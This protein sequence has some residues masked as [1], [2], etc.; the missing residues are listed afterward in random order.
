MSEELIEKYHYHYPKIGSVIRRKKGLPQ[1]LVAM[2]LDYVLGMSSLKNYELGKRDCPASVLREL[3]IFY[4]C[5]MESLFDEPYIS[6]NRDK[7]K[8]SKIPTKFIK[9]ALDAKP[10]SHQT[11]QIEYY[12]D[13]D[14]DFTN[15]KY[16]YIV[17]LED[18]SSLK[19]PKGTRLL[20]KLKE[21]KSID[22]YENEDIFLVNLPMTSKEKMESP[23]KK[24][25]PILTKASLVPGSSKPKIVTWSNGAET[26]YVN[27]RDF[28]SNID[29][30]VVKIIIDSTSKNV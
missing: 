7:E 8:L 30:V 27:Y 2:E 11:S 5:S 16:Q 13:K 26:E 29:G 18:D 14:I 28:L 15:N 6:A 9:N 19:L 12:M 25:R 22:V 17:L 20:L 1:I 3:A 24:A 21:A 4:N 10:V 23:R